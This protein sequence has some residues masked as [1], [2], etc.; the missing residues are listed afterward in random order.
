MLERLNHLS[1]GKSKMEIYV[2]AS[3]KEVERAKF[4]MNKLRELGHEI[5]HDWTVEVEKYKDTI[6]SDE[7]LLKC[8]ENDYQGV[9][10]CDY[11]VLL[12]PK[13]QNSTIG[14]WVELGI[15][16]GLSTDILISGNADKCIFAHLANELYEN[17]EK[18][19]NAIKDR[20]Y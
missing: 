16:L 3:S 10:T 13:D 12:S 8:A 5:T 6:P 4:V 17:D 14:A 18:L 1:I 15:A 9:T 19:I 11:L 7:I 2:A 20:N